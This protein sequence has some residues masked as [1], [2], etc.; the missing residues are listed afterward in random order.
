LAFSS[1]RTSSID[2]GLKGLEIGIFVA[3]V[4]ALNLNECD[5][6]VGNVVQDRKVVVMQLMFLF[7]RFP[8]TQNAIHVQR[9]AVSSMAENLGSVQLTRGCRQKK[10][11]SS[12]KVRQTI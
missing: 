4:I 6:H 11:S 12:L 5:P 10:L 1:F 2:K 9:T 3:L 8:P 7:S